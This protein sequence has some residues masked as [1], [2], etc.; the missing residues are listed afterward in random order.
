M[1][2]LCCTS[3]ETVLLLS[4]YLLSF[5]HFGEIGSAHAERFQEDGVRNALVQAAGVAF[6]RGVICACI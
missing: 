2:P 3:E 5:G 6:Q 4:V 1:G